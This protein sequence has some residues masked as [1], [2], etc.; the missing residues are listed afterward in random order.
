MGEARVVDGDAARRLGGVDR[1][2]ATPSP[3]RLAEDGTAATRCHTT[4][5][6]GR[7]VAWEMTIPAPTPTPDRDTAAAATPVPCGVRRST[8]HNPAT[9]A[10]IGARI[11]PVSAYTTWAA[12]CARTAHRFRSA[13]GRCFSVARCRAVRTFSS[14]PPKAGSRSV[15]ARRSWSSHA[16]N[17]SPIAAKSRTTS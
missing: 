6:G 13:N 5:A 7:G 17:V 9:T 8:H 15:V 14:Q 10:R 11:F 1:R 12:V 4:G 16:A 2:A 3:P